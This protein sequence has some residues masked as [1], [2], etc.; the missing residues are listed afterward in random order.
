MIITMS[1]YTNKKYFLLIALL[2]T[3]KKGIKSRKL[4]E[5]SLSQACC[6]RA[7]CLGP[8]GCWARL[9]GET[10]GGHA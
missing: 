5:N 7:A 9:V 4:W 10:A 3:N 1:L 8:S 2:T 6:G